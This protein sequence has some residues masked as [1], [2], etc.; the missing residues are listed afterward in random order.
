M[1]ESELACREVLGVMS[2]TRMRT[3]SVN[4]ASAIA[5]KWTPHVSRRVFKGRQVSYFVSMCLQAAKKLRKGLSGKMALNMVSDQ[6]H[7]MSEDIDSKRAADTAAFTASQFHFSPLDGFFIQRIEECE[8][9]F[10]SPIKIA[11]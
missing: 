5:E 6:K 9:R 7:L 3:N 8:C 10:C 4:G 1:I 2:S 11:R